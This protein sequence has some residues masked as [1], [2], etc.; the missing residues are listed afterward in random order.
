MPNETHSIC[1][2]LTLYIFRHCKRMG[3]FGVLRSGALS[4]STI[5][6]QTSKLPWLQRGHL[7]LAPFPPQGGKG[8]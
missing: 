1:R 3:L 6:D 8:A 2:V 5:A 4:T 7:F